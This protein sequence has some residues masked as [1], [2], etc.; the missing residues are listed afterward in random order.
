MFKEGFNHLS[1]TSRSCRKTLLMEIPFYTEFSV[2]R[3]FKI[4]LEVD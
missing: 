3:V 4:I 1:N 2:K